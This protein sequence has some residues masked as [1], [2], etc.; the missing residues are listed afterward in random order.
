MGKDIRIKELAT[1]MS[2]VIGYQGPIHGDSAK[3]DGTYRKLLDVS[4]LK[5]LGWTYTIDLEEGI[6]KTYNKYLV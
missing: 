2:K 3:P 6:E 5:N 4:Q 1:T